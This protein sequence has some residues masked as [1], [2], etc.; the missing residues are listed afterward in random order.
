MEI[1]TYLQILNALKWHQYNCCRS[2][3]KSCWLFSTHGLQHAG[4]DEQHSL[5]ITT[6]GACSNSC[7]LS[8]WCHP[9]ISSSVFLF[10]FCLQSFPGSGSFPVSQF[11]ASG[12]P[13][14]FSFIF[15]ISPSSE[16]SGL[17]YFRINWFDLYAVQGTLKS[18]LQHHSSKA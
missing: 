6:P 9:T 10:S 1:I 4:H 8:L 18:P 13:K 17:I 7:P 14:Y 11:F 5:F 15:S 16:Y 12:W 2:V 3:S